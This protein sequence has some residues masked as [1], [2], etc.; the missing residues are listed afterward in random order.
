MR[1]DIE[2]VVALLCIVGDFYCVSLVGVHD[3]GWLLSVV[4][5]SGGMGGLIG[6]VKFHMVGN[7]D[8]GVVI[9]L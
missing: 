7:G 4:W 6:S 8:F 1:L 3:C 9:L 5:W 2:P